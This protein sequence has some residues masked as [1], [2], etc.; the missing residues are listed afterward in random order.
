M[1]DRKKIALC[2]EYPLALRGGVSVLVETL[3]QGL[4]GRYDLVLVSPD[5]SE[6]L[7]KA[8]ISAVIKTHIAWDPGA[9]SQTN[10]KALA[11]RLA[12][13]RIN[14]AHFHLGGTFGWGNRLP[15]QSPMAHLDRLGVPCCSTA[16]M[17]TSL[18]D[19]YC[20]PQK[21][22]WFK[23]AMLPLAWTGKMH[24]LAH[25]RREIVVSRQA[26]DR[27]RKWYRPLA[28]RFTQIYHSRL[29]ENSK[30]PAAIAREPL[31]LSVGHIAFRKGQHVLA[32][33]FAQLA[34][35]YPDWKLLMLGDTVEPE[36]LNR[37]RDI[38]QKH[39]LQERIQLPG[40][41]SDAM[42]VMRRAAIFVQ[43]SFFEGLPLALQEAMF[44]GC[45]CIGTRISGN[46]EI[47]TDGEDG[48]MVKPGEP[49]DLTLALERLM[50]NAGLREELGR[51]STASIVSKGMTV[52]R[53]VARHIELYESIL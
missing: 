30:A 9:V 48:L 28:G 36:C 5:R 22:L 51:K 25:V 38:I 20:G 10:A 39:G 4:A 35:R 46:D 17:V 2:L 27:L 32:E 43:P 29:R 42:D 8:D 37:V 31:V 24:S 6:D 15:N 44:S 40:P 13:E 47:I 12:D 33:A 11:R 3:L 49:G 18:L 52:E 14:L 53:M 34:P 19:G 21:P 1:W 41:R 7:K 50:A 45:A 23:L 16:H 26:C